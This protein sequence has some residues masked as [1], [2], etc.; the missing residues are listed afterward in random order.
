M[1]FIAVGED[2]FLLRQSQQAFSHLYTVHLHDGTT[3][4]DLGHCKKKTALQLHFVTIITEREQ[5]KAL[6]R[7]E[8]LGVCKAFEM[9]SFLFELATGKHVCVISKVLC[10]TTWYF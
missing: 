8:H 2:P 6:M 7:Q 4:C 9:S 1:L 5:H 3:L 10:L